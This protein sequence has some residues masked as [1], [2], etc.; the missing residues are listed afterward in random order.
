MWHISRFF[1]GE[2]FALARRKGVFP[3]K[4]VKSLADYN[5][6]ELPGIEAFYSSLNDEGI[7]EAEYEH[8]NR[9]WDKFNCANLGDYSDTYLRIDVILLADVFENFQNLSLHAYKLDPVWVYSTPGLAW[10]AMLKQ[11][12]VQMEL[13]SDYSMYLFCEAGI[14]GGCCFASE[15]YAKANIPSAVDFDETKGPN[16]LFYIDAN[17]LYGHSMSSPLPLNQFRW[18]EPAEINSL[19]VQA[20]P[21]DGD[22]GF[23]LEVDLEYPLELHKDHND[24]PF[25]PELLKTSAEKHAPRKLIATLHDKKKY[26]IH[27]R[28]LQCAL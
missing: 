5:L 15:R 7:S 10:N 22:I 9:V 13:F 25:C 21:E 6:T 16:H 14:R 3:Y 18:M 27:H 17:N 20:I 26:I 28:H 2:S 23:F 4:F 11:T 1:P 24:L 12:R 19:D 8:A